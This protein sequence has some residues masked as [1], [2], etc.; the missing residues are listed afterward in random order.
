LNK[1]SNWQSLLEVGD[2][3]LKQA[4]VMAEQQKKRN[5]D[6]SQEESQTYI[7]QSFEEL[8]PDCREGHKYKIRVSGGKARRLIESA[9]EFSHQTNLKATYSTEDL[10]EL[11][12]ALKKALDMVEKHKV[13]M[14]SPPVPTFVIRRR[15]ERLKPKNSNEEN[16]ARGPIFGVNLPY[17]GLPNLPNPEFLNLPYPYPKRSRIEHGSYKMVYEEGRTTPTMHIL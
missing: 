13:K 4:T 9:N 2:T 17:P 8:Y 12:T 5:H 14:N 6:S 11:E 3:K 15:S 7:T 16:V 10:S 1:A